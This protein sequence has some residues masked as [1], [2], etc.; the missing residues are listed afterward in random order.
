M[1]ETDADSPLPCFKRVT[2]KPK[3]TRCLAVFGSKTALSL[4]AGTYE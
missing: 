3:N 4:A 1:P 2:K